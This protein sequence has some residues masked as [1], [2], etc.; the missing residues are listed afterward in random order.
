MGID[1]SSSLDEFDELPLE[2]LRRTELSTS[3]FQ[4][5]RQISNK[6]GCG[7]LLVGG[8]GMQ[9]I[10]NLQGDR[11]NKFRPVEVDYIYTFQQLERLR[12]THSTT[13]TRVAD[14]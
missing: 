8:E 4:P 1:Y 9:Q 13:S 2:L 10:I 7:F 12:R 14:C 11:L 5:L 6:P 3:L